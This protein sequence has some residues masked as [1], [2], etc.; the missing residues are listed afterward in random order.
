[1]QTNLKPL[2]DSKE[3]I[4]ELRRGH[5]IVMDY[6]RNALIGFI[7]KGEIAMKENMKKEVLDRMEMLGLH[8]NIIKEFKEEEILNKSLSED[9]FLFYLDD[10]EEEMIKEWEDRCGGMAYHAIRTET[11]IGPMLSILYVSKHEEEWELDRED[12]IN[13]YAIAYVI[14]INDPCCSEA[15]G[16]ALQKINGGLRRII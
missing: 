4:N 3:W 6:K 13:D 16:I 2:L 14:N 10:E 1:M 12:I 9:G 15:G 8:E 11:N 7:K 5:N